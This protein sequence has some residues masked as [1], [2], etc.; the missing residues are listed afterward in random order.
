[1]NESKKAEAKSRFL[2]TSSIYRR[3]CSAHC[4]DFLKLFVNDQLAQKFYTCLQQHGFSF[5]P[6]SSSDQ[7]AE[8]ASNPSTD[9]SA[10]NSADTSNSDMHQSASSTDLANGVTPAGLENSVVST[11]TPAPEVNSALHSTERD[12][13]GT[14]ESS[15]ENNQEKERISHMPGCRLSNLLLAVLQADISLDIQLEVGAL[16]LGAFHAADSVDAI[17]QSIPSIQMLFSRVQN[18]QEHGVFLDKQFGMYVYCIHNGRCATGCL[19]TTICCIR[20]AEGR[21]TV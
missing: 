14:G 16:L 21:R 5:L 6:S 8:S 11:S 7:P 3:C 9:N 15:S 1:M 18:D 12:E 13:Q 4:D 20:P 17:F 19:S 10:D 2:L